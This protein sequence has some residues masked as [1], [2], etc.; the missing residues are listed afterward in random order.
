LQQLTQNHNPLPN[1]GIVP[2]GTPKVTRVS[3]LALYNLS[4]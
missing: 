2:V 3:L 4:L 1:N